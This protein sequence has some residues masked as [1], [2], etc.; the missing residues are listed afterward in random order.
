MGNAGFKIAFVQTEEV[1]PEIKIRCKGRVEEE[2]GKKKRKKY[3][4]FPLMDKENEHR[5]R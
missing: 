1:I 3:Y 5:R 2:K 4:Y